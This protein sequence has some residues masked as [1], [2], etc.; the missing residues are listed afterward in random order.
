MNHLISTEEIESYKQTLLDAY[1]HIENNM[2]DEQIK[3][4][5]GG[6]NYDNTIDL[7]RVHELRSMIITLSHLP[8]ASD[9]KPVLK[10][11]V[12]DLDIARYKLWGAVESSYRRTFGT[13][14]KISIN[15]TQECESALQ[16]INKELHLNE[17][18]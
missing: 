1:N 17:S 13:A 7:K 2:I 16:D 5:Q 6:Y 4:K 9:P 11:D 10:L 15:S 18:R 12:T 8:I 3:A 14:N